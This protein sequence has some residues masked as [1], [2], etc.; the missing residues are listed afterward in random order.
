MTL[1]GQHKSGPRNGAERATEGAKA[2]CGRK[3]GKVKSNQV[4]SRSAQKRILCFGGSGQ[5]LVI[6]PNWAH[7]GQSLRG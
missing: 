5:S 7:A 6:S 1:V 2:G 3:A 4:S